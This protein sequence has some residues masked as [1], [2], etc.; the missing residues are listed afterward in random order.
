VTWT[1]ER[2]E[3]FDRIVFRI[4]QGESR[5]VRAI[6]FVGNYALDDA[7]LLEVIGT[8][9]ARFSS[10]LFGSR[11]SAT[12]VRLAADVESLVDTYRRAGFREARVRV[13]AATDPAALD[14]AALAASLVLADRGNGLYVR[15]TIDEGLP[16]LLTQIEVE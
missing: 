4:D 12:S 2:F 7:A 16:T 10:S 6:D 15:Y 1:R 9:E 8:R 11:T 5:Q 13:S 3:P 14:S